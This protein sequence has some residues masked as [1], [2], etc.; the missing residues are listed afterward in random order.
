MVNGQKYSNDFFLNSWK[1]Q[2]QE[3]YTDKPD[4]SLDDIYLL[5]WQPC[6]TQ[7]KQLLESLTSLSMK[8]SE[9]DSIL[10]PRKAHLET[11]LQLL[12]KGINETSKIYLNPSLLDIAV[13]RVRDYWNLR[14]YQKGA[15]IFL[16]L[17]T[18]LG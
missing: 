12:F 10:E 1:N 6:L 2:L 5:V 4:L 13:R 17:R 15:D 18:S 9:V 14:R 3:A 11:Q 7:C 8:L 16:R